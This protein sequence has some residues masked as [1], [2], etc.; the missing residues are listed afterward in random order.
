MNPM[1]RRLI[2][3][4]LDLLRPALVGYLVVGLAAVAMMAT[5]RESA[6]YFGNVLLLTVVIAAGM[7]VAIVTAVLERTEQTLA[8]VMT[9]PISPRDYVLS[10]VGGGLLIFLVPWTILAASALVMLGSGRLGAEGRA[11]VPFAVLTLMELLAAFCVQLAVAVVTESLAWT[12]VVQVVMNLLLQV[13]L[14]SVSRIP[15][16]AGGLH[17]HRAVWPPVT[18]GLLAAEVAIVPLSLGLAYFLQERK[19]DFL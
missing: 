17:G 8:F 6:F 7:H 3:K 16:I 1:V 4:D 18:L 11:L 9:L 5:G 14:Y 2:L 19:R 10:K 15:A 12:V 13:Y